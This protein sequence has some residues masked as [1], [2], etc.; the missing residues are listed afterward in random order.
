MRLAVPQ[1]KDVSFSNA[2]FREL[3][4]NLTELKIENGKW[5]DQIIFSGSL[6]KEAFDHMQSLGWEMNTF[7]PKSIGGIVDKIRIEYSKPLSQI[8]DRGGTIFDESLAS[9]TINSLP[10]AKTMAK[11]HAAYSGL[12]YTIERSVRPSIEIRLFREIKKI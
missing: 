6:G 10:D 12:K 8:E 9:K 5:P 11:I 3:S 2:L 4:E 1:I 7:N